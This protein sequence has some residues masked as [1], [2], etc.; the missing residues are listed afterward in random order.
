MVGVSIS[1]MKTLRVQSVDRWRDWLDE[2]HAR[3]SEIW[4]VFYKH[5]T[6]VASFSIDDRWSGLK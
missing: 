1:T 4:L 5:H 2:H 3:E 6:G